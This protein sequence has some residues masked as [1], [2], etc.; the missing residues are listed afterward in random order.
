MGETPA[1]ISEELDI[2]AQSISNWKSDPL[3]ASELAEM[4]MKAESRML[5]ST[6]RVT[7]MAK[8]NAAAATAA[9][10]CVKAIEGQIG[11]G[12]FVEAVP[13]NARL[14]SAWDI[15]DRTGNSKKNEKAVDTLVDAASLIIE[16]YSKK[17]GSTECSE[18]G[19][20][21]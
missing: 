8:L 9:D 7:A 17:H 16:A 2:T 15:L 19:S 6:E 14:K 11:E 1:E 3:F 21:S 4:E 18:S 13:L 5:D 10:L 20:E 12:E